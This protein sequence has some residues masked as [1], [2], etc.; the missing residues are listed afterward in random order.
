MRVSLVWIVAILGL[1]LI[2]CAPTT[3]QIDKTVVDSLR[4]DLLVAYG[5][6][7][8]RLGVLCRDVARNDPECVNAQAF[9]D[10]L[11]AAYKAFRTSLRDNT[12]DPTVLR[13]VLGLVGQ[14][15]P[16]GL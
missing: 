5:E 11:A 8:G 16:L 4:D 9:L 12:I 14:F 1:A 15:A 7:R 10:R 13:E 3:Y 6:Q 2:G